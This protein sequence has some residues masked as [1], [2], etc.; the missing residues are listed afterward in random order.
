MNEIIKPVPLHY[1]IE[2][3]KLRGD[4]SMLC[5][6]CLSASFE[7]VLDDDHSE[8]EPRR[9]LS[10]EEEFRRDDYRARLRDWR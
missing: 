2:C 6:D 1:C 5:A 8:R 9:Q 3:A 10:D 4:M 7:D